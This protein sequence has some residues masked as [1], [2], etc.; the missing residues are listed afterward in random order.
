MFHKDGS[1]VSFNGKKFKDAP[2]RK[3]DRRNLRNL[4]SSTLLSGG[5]AEAD[6]EAEVDP[7]LSVVLD[8]VFLKGSLL[9]RSVLLKDGKKATLYYRSPEEE[10][11]ATEEPQE[12][13]DPFK[14]WPYRDTHQ[15]VWIQLPQDQRSQVISLPSLALLAVLFHAAAVYAERG[16]DYLASPVKGMPVVVVPPA[17]SKY[18]CRGAHLMR[19]G[20][21]RA[22]IPSVSC[23]S[24]EQVS[25]PVPVGLH[26][27]VV[28]VSGNPQPFAVGILNYSEDFWTNRKGVAVSIVT[29]YGDDLWRQQCIHSSHGRGST[30]PSEAKVSAMGG[31]PFGAGDYGNVGFLQGGIVTSIVN[32]T[33]VP[34]NAA[35][36]HDV[37]SNH[38]SDKKSTVAPVEAD[39]E[40]SM[41]EKEE[42]HPSGTG[43][44]NETE[45]PIPDESTVPLGPSQDELLHRALCRALVR[46]K[47][48][49][50]PM[51]VATFYAQHVLAH[52]DDGTTIELK[53]TRWKKFSAY[54]KEQVD[55][56][57]VMVAAD[58]TKMDPMARLTGYDKRHE[59]L[60]DFVA[61]KKGDLSVDQ[62]L[63]AIKK[64]VLVDLYCI[65]HH[66]QSL[67]RLDPSA[68]SAGNATSSERRGTGKL[69]MKESRQILDD[70]VVREDLVH[71]T[72]PNMVVLDGPLTDALFK[73][74]KETET[75]PIP[76]RMIRKELADAW[77]K[78][79]DTAYALVEMPGNRIVRMGRGK[80]PSVLIE[81][82]RR[83]S[84][85]FVTRIRGLEQY[86]INPSHFSREAATRFA[87][88]ATVE[89]GP[90][91]GV[92]VLVQ[93]NLVEEL[94]A[95][96]IG[97]ERLTVHG[98][99][100][101]SPFRIPKNAINVE[102]RKGVPTRKK[103]K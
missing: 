59:D 72:I 46:L 17:A 70:Y 88:A 53:R 14:C 84:N 9:C 45:P 33:V 69:T 29:S 52:R 87:L 18:V 21:I 95:L 1:T 3:S 65:P 101:D 42:R 103:K 49:E 38:S 76:E 23:L 67:L 50:L 90:A 12:G 60:R 54:L 68:M 25:V 2:V 7:Y 75:A 82:S 43:A 15:C 74:K 99:A 73:G 47:G 91:K 4:V 37:P 13:C 83:Q 86:G 36:E 51:T 100:R 92:D 98:G 80:A 41:D 71:P 93:G 81:V 94:E 32:T 22:F 30:L 96:L 55:R 89:E 26:P 66:F 16:G 102:L 28:M 63:G 44:V 39:R 78:K 61:E 48:S 11:D 8:H 24:E 64:L 85:K 20:V 77:I 27:A 6:K 97:D 57:L 10:D 35:D 62:N 56:G 79:L 34:E 5:R 31:A 58:A 40:I 19:A